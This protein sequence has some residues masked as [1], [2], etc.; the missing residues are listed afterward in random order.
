[1]IVKLEYIWLDG[2]QPEP[3]L[4]SK[5]KVINLFD[6]NPLDLNRCPEWSF[7]GSST[8]QAEGSFSDCILKP[9]RLYKNPLNTGTI[10]SF[11]VLCEVMNPDGTPHKTNTRATIG[12]EQEDLWFG[13]EQEYTIMSNGRPLGFP[14]N[15]YPEPQG[16]YYCGVGNGQVNG[17]VFVDKHMENCVRAGINITGTNAEVL[18]GQWEY[19][20]FSMGKLKAGDDLWVTRYILQQMSENYG[21]K[22]EFHPKP[23]MGDWNGSGLH[24]NF[25]SER[26]RNEGGEE[27]FKSIFNAFDMR[28]ET[29]IDSYGSDNEL[30]LTGKHETQSIDKFSWGIADRGASIRVP[31]ST[32]KN[33]KGYIEDRRPASNGDPYRIVKVIS[34]TLDFALELY[35]IKTNIGYHKDIESLIDVFG[36]TS[37]DEL[38]NEYRNDE[39]YELSSEMMESKA[40]IST[41]TI[42]FELKNK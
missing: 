3:N 15:G 5:V 28:H 35:N 29:H 17:R 9:V 27:Y 42:D 1:M 36:G 41:E 2:Y 14:T 31:L 26:M 13:F 4:R 39:N 25:S 7:D 32:A 6:E 38:L 19:Q 12:D 16:K 30:R 20:V 21:F 10:E 37:N 18:L 33:W 40:N 8:K 11:L 23:V 34:Q 22:I 24:C